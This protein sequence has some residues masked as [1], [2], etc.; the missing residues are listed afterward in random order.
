MHQ[1]AL[2]VATATILHNAPNS[3]HKALHS[4]KCWLMVI[5]IG[6]AVGR[7]YN[8]LLLFL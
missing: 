2:G 8:R 6:A 1:F 5:H 4:A 3:V 7:R